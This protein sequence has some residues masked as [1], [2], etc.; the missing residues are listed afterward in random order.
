MLLTTVPGLALATPETDDYLFS[1]EEQFSVDLLTEDLLDEDLF[2]YLEPCEQDFFEAI[3]GE[4]F[5]DNSVIVILTRAESRM[6]SRDNRSFAAIDFSDVG[7]VYV[8]DLLYLD[9]DQNIYA[10]ELW[11][12]ERLV[13]LSEASFSTF[14]DEVFL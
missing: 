11:D 12:A 10:Q 2:F 3:P 8:E 6:T 7:A 4:S 1:S 9:E 5:E 14:S 13:A